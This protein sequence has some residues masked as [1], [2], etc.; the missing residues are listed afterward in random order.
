LK[1]ATDGGE[2]RRNANFAAA[3]LLVPQ[4]LPAGETEVREL[5]AR[6]KPEVAR[7]VMKGD[8]SESPSLEA[9][10]G[11]PSTR[12]LD[13]LFVCA[14]GQEIQKKRNHIHLLNHDGVCRKDLQNAGK[15]L[16]AADYTYDRRACLSFIERLVA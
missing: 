12:R 8:R 6:F 14:L 5:L 11:K 9:A 16:C 2:W 15:R 4:L 13:E 3:I 1:T 7:E 10:T